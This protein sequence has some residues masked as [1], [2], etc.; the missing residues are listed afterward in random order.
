MPVASKAKRRLRRLKRENTLT[1]R[2]LDLAIKQR[3]YARMV[4]AGLE[5]E[6]KKYTDDP[7]PE[8]EDP[9]PIQPT[10]IWEDEGGNPAPEA[11]PEVTI[12]KTG[13]T[14]E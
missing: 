9:T 14:L 7:F 11:K 12:V 4:A 2:G 6:L 1:Y 8:G 5:A 3:D 13:E 10:E